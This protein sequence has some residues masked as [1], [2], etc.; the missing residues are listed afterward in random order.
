MAKIGSLE[1]DLR[2]ETAAF[3]ADMNKATTLLNSNVAQ[4][5]R[6]VSGLEASFKQVQQVASTMG[7]AL[8][9]ALAIGGA[10]QVLKMAD[11]YNKLVA[12]LDNATRSTRDLTAVQNQLIAIA[13]ATGT[14]F[15]DNVEVFQRLS[16]GAK[17]LG[18]SNTDVLK[19]VETVDQLG[20]ISGASA[21]A[22]QAG[23]MQFGQA[24]AGGV[25][26]AE[27]FN[28]VV[29]N[30]PALAQRIADGMGMSIGQLRQE[31]LKGG[32]DS[33]A[34]FDAII[35]QSESV[36]AEFE[37]MPP[38][39]SKAANNLQVSL[40][41]VVGN[42]DQ[43]TGTTQKL[44]NMMDSAANSVTAFFSDASKTAPLVGLI[45][46]LES[47]TKA[48]G[49]FGGALM[50]IPGVSQAVNGPLRDIG[51][52]MDFIASSA[53]VAGAEIR[54]FVDGTAALLSGDFRASTYR[55]IRL[56]AEDA[57]RQANA[58]MAMG[59]AIRRGGTPFALSGNAAD[60]MSPLDRLSPFNLGG[61]S[62][63]VPGRTNTRVT[64][65]GTG[66]G[67]RGGGGRGRSGGGGRGSSKSPLQQQ[68]E[69][70]KRAA[71]QITA[72]TR[73][74]YER[75]AVEMVKVERL[76]VK[77]LIT[78]DTYTRKVKELNAEVERQ[79]S[80]N[81]PRGSIEEGIKQRLGVLFAEPEE[82]AQGV[83][84]SQEYNESLRQAREIY[85]QMET[86]LEKLQNALK[87][88]QRLQMEE[89]LD[90]E[91]AQ[92][93][94]AKLV[95][96]YDAL[97][98]QGQQSVNT[99]ELAVQNFGRNFENTFI[100]ASMTG[101]FAFKDFVSSAMEDLARL[102]FRLTVINPIVEGITGKLSGKKSGGSLIGGLLSSIAGGLIGG[103][104]KGATPLGPVATIAGKRAAGGPVSAGKTYLVGEEGPELFTPG[105]AGGITPNDEMGGAP[106]IYQTININATD[107]ESFRA[108]LKRE[109]NL[110][111]AM[112]VQAVQQSE[113]KRGRR[114]PLDRR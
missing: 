22:M 52:I 60:F 85:E 14:S 50:G 89:V 66:G 99:L 104:G 87:N 95:A 106:V 24:M 48:V 88:I 11:D 97:E 41:Q 103:G 107:A 9:G 55:A 63:M 75:L 90:P 34:V 42:L 108:L 17:D 33:K 37:R 4:M 39:M 56:R 70:D 46:T 81:D 26:R 105:R 30:L 62:A 18:A 15:Q 109:G 36:R 19:L 49:E 5:K 84:L 72:E 40:Q 59:E 67:G 69:D 10:G 91:T 57:K 3:R 38:T 64:P 113:N 58:D 111:G 94:A 78:L 8:G 27:E 74:M 25:M 12:R 73:T 65:A 45:W 92:S 71:E 21:S 76:R 16:M 31:M 80:L 101:K 28:S 112:G 96:D 61:G 93:Y 110:I 35:S 7:A 68:A 79:I 54:E 98:K 29:E 32:L 6:A 53:R 23:L 43:T 86:P 44:A 83:K 2:A 20:T 77:G 1:I 82:L 13:K 102:I 51:S 100:Q 114:G 47:A